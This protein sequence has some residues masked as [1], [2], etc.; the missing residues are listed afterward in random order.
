MDINEKF[1]IYRLHAEFC[2][3]LSDANR[4][5]II[6]ELSR[7]ELSVNELTRKLG[8]QQSNVSKHL[9]LMREHGLVNARRDGS[10]IFYTVS[11]H[12]IYE[13]INLL[14]AAQS[15]QLEKRRKL[16]GIKP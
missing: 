2:K 3:T 8:L 4:L 16:A 11:D 14:K 6:A 5:L 9:A 15:D 7:G 10:T 12:R 1:E 13:A